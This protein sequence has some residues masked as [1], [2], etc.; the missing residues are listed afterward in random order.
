MCGS[1]KKCCHVYHI[2]HWRG[3]G[4]RYRELN[5]MMYSAAREVLVAEM[6]AQALVATATRRDSA[7]WIEWVGPDPRVLRTLGEARGLEGA[8]APVRRGHARLQ[9]QERSPLGD[10]GVHGARQ[11]EWE[12]MQSEMSSVLSFR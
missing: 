9:G 7:G 1:R 10:R 2:P 5:D 12:K 6:V 8:A 4:A 3:N 11:C